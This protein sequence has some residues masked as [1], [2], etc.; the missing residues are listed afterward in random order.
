M[1][2]S[3]LVD[4]P[5]EINQ[6]VERPV[7]AGSEY[8]YN[9]DQKW[10]QLQQFLPAAYHM[11]AEEAPRESVWG[12]CDYHVHVERYANP[13]AKAKIILLH[14]VGTNSRQLSMIV[15][16][17]LSTAGLETVAIDLPPYGLSV[18]ESGMP[19]L[20]DD[21]VEIV[22]RF[23]QYEQQRDGRPIIL[24]GLSAGGM[25][26]YHVAAKYPHIAGIIG[27]TFLD[28]RIQQVRDQTSK[29]LLMSRLGY[30]TGPFCF[31]HANWQ[32]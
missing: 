6:P 23:V 22:I 5:H 9:C 3:P 26:A 21:W 32:H 11:S 1:T 15:G 25:L 27:M 13:D 31:R 12:W 17:P 2:E 18:N 24:Y 30:Y 7:Q 10:Q 29:N 8:S 16:K 20:Y 19:I 14:G 28:Q 4:I